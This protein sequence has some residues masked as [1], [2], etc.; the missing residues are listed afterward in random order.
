ME[1]KAGCINLHFEGMRGDF[2]WETL[3]LQIFSVEMKKNK[4]DGSAVA[5]SQAS[6]WKG[7]TRDL[8]QTA[9]YLRD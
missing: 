3:V 8:Q 7:N 5:S 4:W 2:G 6:T 9:L 1:Y